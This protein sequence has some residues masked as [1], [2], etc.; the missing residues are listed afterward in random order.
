[1]QPG[2][3]ASHFAVLKDPRTANRCRHKF[4]DIVIMAV[5][6]ALCGME[7]WTEVEFFAKHEAE[8]LGSFLELPGGVP[9]HDTFGR[10]FALMDP[11][12]FTAVFLDWVNTVKAEL[13]GDIIAL[14]GKSSRRTFDRAAEKSP[15]HMVSAFSHGSGLVLGQRAVDGK[16]NEI[17]AIPELLKLIPIKGK[18]ITI[19]AMGCQKKIAKLIVEGKGDYLL[20]LKGNH[21]RLHAELRDYFNL[22]R[23]T[24]FKDIPYS[25]SE[26]TD[27]GHGRIEIRRIWCTEALGWLESKSDW[28]GLKTLVAIESTRI[29]GDKTSVE[30]RLFLSSLPS[31][32]PYRIGE[33]ARGH[34]AIENRLH[35]VLDAVMNEDQSRLRKGNAPEVMAIMRHIVLNLLRMDTATKG[36]I[37]CKR[38]LAG[39][40]QAY[41][42]Q[43]LFGFPKI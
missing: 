16:S 14:D 31:T 15:L 7:H 42:L 33:I 13:P 5:L 43:A 36:S 40:N 25:Y 20:A 32:N 22:G 34:W 9:S 30:T 28:T 1:M 27:K 10:V 26:S 35:W 4:L 12:A 6:G 29:L 21:E 2:S 3:L 23:E 19:D 11:K 24:N 8:W 39:W 38:M 17:T 41:R 18:I 37:R